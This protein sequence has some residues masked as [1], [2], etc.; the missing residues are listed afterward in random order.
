M[1]DIYAYN[2]VENFTIHDIKDVSQCTAE[3]VL[4]FTENK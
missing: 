1:T 4:L 2:Y 3:I